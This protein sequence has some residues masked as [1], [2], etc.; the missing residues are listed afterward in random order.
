MVKISFD[1]DG[2]K[3]LPD[4]RIGNERVRGQSSLGNK[5]IVCEEH[6]T[7][8]QCYI[9]WKGILTLCCRACIVKYCH[10]TTAVRRQRWDERLSEHPLGHS[11]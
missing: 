1:K 11:Y 10:R 2:R 5:Q 3:I 7:V 9:S 6:G 8:P 4:V